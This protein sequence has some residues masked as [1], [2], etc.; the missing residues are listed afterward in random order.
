MIKDPK[1]PWKRHCFQIYNANGDR[2][3]HTGIGQLPAHRSAEAEENAELIVEAVNAFTNDVSK[4]E[5][6]NGIPWYDH[7]E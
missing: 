4:S 7:C 1:T 3:A 2:V 6:D 5:A